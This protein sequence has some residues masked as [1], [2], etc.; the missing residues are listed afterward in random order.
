MGVL[1]SILL[2]NLRIG[3]YLCALIVDVF[4]MLHIDLTLA[5]YLIACLVSIMPART[6][7]VYVSLFCAL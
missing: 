4:L 6:A 1:A 5:T 7:R 2:L 3:G